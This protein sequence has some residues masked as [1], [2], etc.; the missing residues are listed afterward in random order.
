M[1]PAS[2]FL[3]IIQA[4]R[5]QQMRRSQLLL[6]ARSS[7]EARPGAVTRLLA[8]WRTHRGDGAAQAGCPSPVA[9]GAA[10]CC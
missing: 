2:H 6:M 7:A 10:V 8:A 3:S 9:T 5:E 1:I 4:E